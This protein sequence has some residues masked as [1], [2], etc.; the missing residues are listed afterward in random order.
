MEGEGGSEPFWLGLGFQPT[1]EIEDKEIA[2][3]LR[4]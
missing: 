3:R 2:A 1:G 4:L